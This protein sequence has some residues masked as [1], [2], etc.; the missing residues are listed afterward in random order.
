MARRYAHT[1]MFTLLL[2]LDCVIHLLIY[3]QR[4]NANFWEQGDKVPLIDCNKS[5]HR[6]LTRCE[7]HF[8]FLRARVNDPDKDLSRRS[9]PIDDSIDHR[10]IRIASRLIE[11]AF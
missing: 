11:Q 6:R 5:R 9:V 3:A 2:A 8:A 4:N 7:S 10:L 1:V